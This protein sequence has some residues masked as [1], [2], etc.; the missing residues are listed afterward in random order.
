MK[1]FNKGKVVYFV[2]S[3][4]LLRKLLLCA[5]M[6]DF[7]P[8]DS[9]MAIVVHLER[10]LV[11]VNCI[12]QKKRQRM[13]LSNIKMQTSGDDDFTSTFYFGLA[14]TIPPILNL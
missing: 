12:V 6:V 9:K 5:M 2:P 7:A 11:K 4:I 1:Q 13:L 8:F 3:S 10:V 14:N